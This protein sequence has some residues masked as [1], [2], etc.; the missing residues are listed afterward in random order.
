[1]TTTDGELQFEWE[2]LLSFDEADAHLL[3]V[4]DS[5][6][7][8]RSK[9]G[10][11]AATMVFGM[12]TP[13]DLKALVSLAMVGEM[14]VGVIGSWDDEGDFDVQWYVCKGRKAPLG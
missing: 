10:A 6:V 5:L 2:P 9:F 11:G 12:E 3:K 4:L 8:E 1:M 7:M 14:P 13:H